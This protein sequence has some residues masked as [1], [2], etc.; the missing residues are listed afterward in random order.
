MII[1]F[2]LFRFIKKKGKS[3]IKERSDLESDFEME[4]EKE[5]GRLSF[6]GRKGMQLSQSF[7]H[8]SVDLTI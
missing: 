1:L 7:V 2:L 4:F 8:E 6:E 3:A 5:L